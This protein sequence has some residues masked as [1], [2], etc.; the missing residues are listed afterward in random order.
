MTIFIII[1]AFYWMAVVADIVTTKGAIARNAGRESNRDFL[2]DRGR[3]RYGKN[4][5]MSA[6]TWGAG[7]LAFFVVQAPVGPVV[8][9]VWIAIR[10]A[11]RL[12]AAVHNHR[13]GRYA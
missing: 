4:V 1:S 3:V 9:L 10:G 12:K 7:A 13:L 2:D 8:G 6:A 11:F 5:L